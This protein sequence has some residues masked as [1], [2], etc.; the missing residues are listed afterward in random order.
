MSCDMKN[1][2][3]G[4][5]GMLS[6]MKGMLTIWNEKSSRLKYWNLKFEANGAKL[7]QCLSFSFKSGFQIHLIILKQK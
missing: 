2:Y 4:A 7:I 6:Q 1:P 3:V 5:E